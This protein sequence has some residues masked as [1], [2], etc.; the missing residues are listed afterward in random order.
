MAIPSSGLHGAHLRRDLVDQFGR[1]RVAGALSGGELRPLWTGVV[2]D[3][4]RL[5]DPLTRA[6]AGLLTAGPRAVLTG[7]TAALLHGCSSMDSL[8]THVLVPYGCALRSRSGLVVH[9][10]GFF[11]DD[12]AQLDGLRVLAF[13]RVIADLLCTLRPQNALAVADEALRLARDD[14]EV[15]RKEVARRLRSRQDPRGTVRA[16]GLLDLASPRADSPP[17]SWL[18]WLLVDDGFPIPEVN[19]PIRTS[20]GRE[21]FRLD[22]AWPSLRVS[23]EYDGRASHTGREAEDEAR[24]EELRRWGWIV[25]RADRDDLRDLTRLA[26]KLRAAFAERGYTW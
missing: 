12:I 10:G 24:D 14:H 6:A 23:V 18:R 7:A 4:A 11:A 19:W 26:A 8:E 16:A 21:V 1:R 17:E 2:V 20:G 9:H 25:V 15:L 22:L 13:D 5:L 3:A